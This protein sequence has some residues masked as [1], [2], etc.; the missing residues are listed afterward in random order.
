M[1]KVPRKGGVMIPAKDG[2]VMI[3]VKHGGVV[4]PAEHGDKFL[5]EISS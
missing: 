3:L 4:I 2:G 5:N 1:K